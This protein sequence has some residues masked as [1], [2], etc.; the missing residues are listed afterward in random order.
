MSAR[1]AARRFLG[2]WS[3][4][5]ILKEEFDLLRPPA[6]VS[7]QPPAGQAAHPHEPKAPWGVTSEDISAAER[8][9]R[10]LAEL[11]FYRELAMC[12]VRTHQTPAQQAG[13]RMSGW[14]SIPAS[15]SYVSNVERV[16][17]ELREKP[18]EY[19]F[20]RALE[21]E[22]A[23]LVGV[24]APLLQSERGKALAR[25]APDL[26]SV[27]E[28]DREDTRHRFNRAVLEAAFTGF[29]RSVDDRECASL[30]RAFAEA[31]NATPEGK[32]R[33]YRW[34]LSLSG[35]GIRSASFS[36]GVLQA[37]AHAGYLGRFDYV[38]TVSGGGY[39]GSWLSAWIAREG[40]DAAL[41]KLAT[42]SG[43]PLTPEAA[44]VQHLRLFSRY[45]SPHRGVF[46]AD[47]WTLIAT[48]LRN[49][50]LNWM[51]ILPFIAAMMIVPLLAASIVGHPPT[52]ERTIR[53]GFTLLMLLAFVC[54]VTG[55]WFVHAHRPSSRHAGDDASGDS[56][57]AIAHLLKHSG[58]RAFL[59]YCLLPLSVSAIVVNTILY[60]I[61]ISADVQRQFPFMSEPL[62]VPGV[63]AVGDISMSVIVLAA[64]GVAAHSLGAIIAGWRG[65][66]ESHEGTHTVLGA[67]NVVVSG[68]VAGSAAYGIAKGIRAASGL[69]DPVVSHALAGFARAVDAKPEA[70]M[71]SILAFPGFI[72]ALAVASFLY[73]GLSSPHRSDEEREWSARYTAWLLMT[74]VA[75]LVIA[76]IVAASGWVLSNGFQRV[77][78]GF[79]ISLG[80]ATAVL[81][82]SSFSGGK[83]S[84]TKAKGEST[85]IK[86]IVSQFG[87]ALFAPVA[88]VLIMM[89]IASLDVRLLDYTGTFGVWPPTIVLATGV[90]LL[91]IS[92]IVSR[93]IDVNKFS[94]HA[95]YRARLI[96]AYLGASRLAGARRANPFTG[97][98]PADNMNMAAMM[99][100]KT[101]GRPIHII[102]AA[103]NLTGG[104]SLGWQDRQARSFTM[105]PL[106]AGAA[107]IGYR[108][109][110]YR[111][112]PD[113]SYA[114]AHGGISLGT[115]MAISGAAASPNMGYHS[116]KA[117]T[118]LMTIFNARLGWW[119][120]NTGW[121]GRDNFHDASPNVPISP[122]FPEL[123]G[124]TRDSDP[125]IYLSDGGHFENLGLYEMVLRRCRLIVVADS[126]ADPTYK[127]DDLGSAIAKIRI[128]MGIPIEFDSPNEIRPRDDKGNLEPAGKHG[129][130]ARI[131]YSTID[132]GADDG[133]LVYIK[134]ALNGDEPADV[135]AYSR[136]SPTFPQ[137]STA[138]QFFSEQQLESYRALGY[139]STN[140]VLD[141][142]VREKL[143]EQLA[144]GKRFF[145]SLSS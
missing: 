88:M 117:V 42:P 23:V 84:E 141:D 7:A 121:P 67:V 35:G 66:T 46:T 99:N 20:N 101:G 31:E 104:S 59:L 9:A 76:G 52:G 55:V 93:R 107:G 81:G 56:I 58:E 114:G 63:P 26:D 86:A 33:G 115:A 120:G 45:L 40:K 24:C 16:E 29:I 138:E 94:L 95:M 3:L 119:L 43:D 41:A 2:P 134:P 118:F 30:F 98:D 4:F 32:E 15:E 17:Q 28:V 13:T 129:S 79:G 78:S 68:L 44:P 12:I 54:A 36:L 126:S 87:I 25:N 83:S 102:N 92:Y 132:P 47:L 61:G 145:P 8:T 143:A 48:M 39:I 62:A 111:N 69:L 85:G 5:E 10:R 124:L 139:H 109:T 136:S 140:R 144:S 97:F 37:L 14:F 27:D 18:P 106:H 22:P 38:S 90:V 19:T 133:L 137:E 130:T 64:F 127:F 116:S 74:A 1:N 75:W 6:P 34:A 70:I 105:S 128:D 96:R 108:R 49:M 72:V 91:M 65:P 82:N 103:L 21:L 53:I 77:L 112:T 71:Y 57:R 131:C 89:T 123:L 11:R 80:G 110:R 73:I 142:G 60:W 125:L 50:L 100:E 135:L 51:M 113:E 122:I